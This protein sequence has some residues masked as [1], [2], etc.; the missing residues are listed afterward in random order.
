MMELNKDNISIEEYQEIVEDHYQYAKDSVEK[1]MPNL[2]AMLPT[3]LSED[4]AQKMQDSI[5]SVLGG[6][7]LLDAALGKPVRPSNE[8]ME[9]TIDGEEFMFP[10]EPKLYEEE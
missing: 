9:V 7:G 8:L 10:V 3:E 5:T 4:E 1:M 2:L 6:T